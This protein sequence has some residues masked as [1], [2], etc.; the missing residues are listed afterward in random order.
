MGMFLGILGGLIIIGILF[1]IFPH[2]GQMP[3]NRDYAYG[4]NQ[5]PK[6]NFIFGLM[7]FIALFL[8][9]Y[10]KYGLE[11]KMNWFVTILCFIAIYFIFVMICVYVSMYID[12]YKKKK[13]KSK[14]K[15]R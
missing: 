11:V 9:G 2:F 10:I 8:V 14:K 6:E 15:K 7:F 1:A 5:D 3:V 12:K 13:K 4:H